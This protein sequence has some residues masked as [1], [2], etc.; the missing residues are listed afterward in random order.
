M[1]VAV[2]KGGSKFHGNDKQTLNKTQTHWIITLRTSKANLITTGAMY[3]NPSS[4]NSGLLLLISWFL[5]SWI[6]QKIVHE[7][8]DYHEIL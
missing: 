7:K 6:K 1:N 3:Q 8:N 5:K 4:E 2:E